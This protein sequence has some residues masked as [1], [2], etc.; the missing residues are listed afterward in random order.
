MTYEERVMSRNS[1]NAV[2]RINDAAR[3]E[4]ARQASKGRI[5]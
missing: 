2:A 3:A 4:A 5:I 1:Y